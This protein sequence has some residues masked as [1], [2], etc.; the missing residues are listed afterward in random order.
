MSRLPWDFG[1]EG[2]RLDTVLAEIER[3]MIEHA[4]VLAGE[5]TTRAARL[6]G[7]HRTTLAEKLRR[8]HR[9]NEPLGRFCHPVRRKGS[10][11]APTDG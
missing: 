1:R 3:Q 8:A 11:T 2:T 9:R 5:N 7:I 4:F 6:L 10:P